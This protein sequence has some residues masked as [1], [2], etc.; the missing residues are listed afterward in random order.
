MGI[1]KCKRRTDL[2]CFVHNKPVCDNCIVDHAIC[3]V[4]TYPEWLAS[5]EYPPPTCAKC[6]QG[7]V[8]GEEV[9]RLK[10]LELFHPHCIDN[11]LKN[12]GS[13]RIAT[14]GCPSCN[15]AILP[16][17]S[18]TSA[19]A[20]SIRSKLETLPSAPSIPRPAS[21]E[22]SN[23]LPHPTAH[24]FS[25]PSST[26]KAART[27][28]TVTSVSVPTTPATVV[29]MPMIEQPTGRKIRTS[30]SIE[31][32]GMDADDD[33]YGRKTILDRLGIR[34]FFKRINLMQQQSPGL[35]R[36]LMLGCIAFLSVLI[37]YLLITSLSDD[38]AE[39]NIT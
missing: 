3:H 39:V 23:A 24:T 10:C 34:A 9:L 28:E 38:E 37:I 1:C 8:E 13:E 4:R 26:S 16:S 36:K 18:D 21:S 32:P 30:R 17:S 2:Y 22:P 33:K 35:V 31:M 14:S 5:S 6:H 19:L 7:L 29:P 15:I 12:V 25:T 20:N 27:R 11:H